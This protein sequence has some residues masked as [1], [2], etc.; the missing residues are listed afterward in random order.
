VGDLV[1]GMLVPHTPRFFE[2]DGAPA[3]FQPVIRGLKAL[4]DEVA[5]L[6]PDAIIIA[7][8]HWVT[9]FHHYVSGASRLAGLLT[10]TEAPDLI[11]SVP[12]DYPGDPELA[13]AL[14]AAGVAERVPAILTAESTLPLD[15]GTVI[16]LRYLTP[17]GRIPIVPISLCHLADLAETLRW[18]RAI[19]AAVCAGRKR[20]VLA[21]TGALSH[22]LVRGPERWPEMDCRELDDR[23][24]DLFTAGDLVAL[25]TSLGEF[26]Q[27]AQVE[28]GGRHLALLIGALGS[29]YRG[30]VLGY[31]PSSGSG[32]A[33]VTL[34]PN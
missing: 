10:A 9:T 13:Q 7:S 2:P 17:D 22:R 5:R 21:V 12:Y 30:R 24:M 6:G 15:Y 33:V 29:G 18:G 28:A 20:V 34:S 1:R 4:G 3:V 19:R 14:V 26:T 11:R 31:G 23:M 8:A 32:N 16:P 25:E 27:A